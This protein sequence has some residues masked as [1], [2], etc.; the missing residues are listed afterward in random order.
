MKQPIV[1]SLS[2]IKKRGLF[3]FTKL[4][5]KK[6]FNELIGGVA[7]LTVYRKSS[8]KKKLA[9]ILDENKNKPV[10]IW[11]HLTEWKIP[12]FQRPQH[13]AINLSKQGFLYLYLTGKMHDRL[14]G[15]KKINN[16]NS[17]YLVSYKFHN[18][19]TNE[20]PDKKIIHIYSTDYT[21]DKEFVINEL[22]NGNIV[23]YEYVDEISED[24]SRF[25]IGKDYIDAHNY[26][27]S[28]ERCIV[29]TTASK[30]YDNVAKIRNKNFTLVS[31]GVDYE[32]FSQQFTYDKAPIKIKNIL[33][34]NKKIIG[35]YGALASWFDYD[36]V[37]KIAQ[38]DKYEVLIIGCDYDNSRFK[39]SLE[40]YKNI[41]ILKPV[42][43]DKLPQYA[44]WFDV[45]IIPFLINDVT[46]STSPIKL[47]EYMAL[48]KPILTTNIP[49]CHKYKSVLIGTDHNDFIEKLE[50]AI[51]LKGDESYK[52]L[53][54]KEALENSWSEKAK[55][56]SEIII[57]QLKN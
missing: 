12:L 48:G 55:V 14:Y 3:A 34:K 6:I 39:Q 56:I 38:N 46:E 35:Y 7:R 33:N 53:L 42:P 17:L 43:Y 19:I 44:Y 25:P 41:N 36:L 29:I 40:K 51:S 1:K 50:K 22:N 30:L 32:H 15:I 26:I 16:N 31:N 5:I 52:S 2:Y 47:F 49:E 9:K 28:D 24:I 18:L 10:I 20:I 57:E 11:N 4:A 23:L 21:L 27:L 8:I 54:K 45:A 13:I 37:K